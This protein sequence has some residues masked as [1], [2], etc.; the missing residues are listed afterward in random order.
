M[1]LFAA[2]QEIAGVYDR[3][4]N[5]TIILANQA[6]GNDSGSVNGALL[7]A[8]NTLSGGASTSIN[9]ALANLATVAGGSLEGIDT[10]AITALSGP[11]SN[12]VFALDP[13]TLADKSG[14]FPT[15]TATRASAKYSPIYDRTLTEFPVDQHTVWRGDWSGSAWS[16]NAAEA[17]ESHSGVTCSTVS[18]LYCSPA[19]TNILPYSDDLTGGSWT[20]GTATITA[21]AG[22]APDGTATASKVQNCPTTAGPSY[23][24]T[25]T[26]STYI[27]AG[28]WIKRISTTGTLIVQNVAGTGS[29]S[30][31][32]SLLDDGW[33]YIT[34]R[35]EGIVN[36]VNLQAD[37]SGNTGP[38]FVAAAGTVDF[39]VWG[40]TWLAGP[41]GISETVSIPTSGAE[42]TRA[43]DSAVAY[44]GGTVPNAG[45]VVMS[46]S[47]PYGV[48]Y[49][50]FSQRMLGAGGTGEN[51]D[52]RFASNG[53][54]VSCTTSTNGS[55]N[56][57]QAGTAGQYDMAREERVT[58]AFR[59][60]GS[61]AQLG[62]KKE[63]DAGTWLWG[64]ENVWNNAE[65]ADTLNL[66]NGPNSSSPDTVIHYAMVYNEC[67]T[68]AAIEAEFV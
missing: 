27:H 52:L 6:L 45:T 28:F 31:D 20:S 16:R 8:A 35:T 57:V 1:G 48:S 64:T 9:G 24:L 42:V 66:F 53:M 49:D 29:M 54:V 30:I 36:V 39:Y 61:V 5:E 62:I 63:Y 7:Q 15:V 60:G 58:I 67:L 26:A 33:N 68:T 12:V 51:F 17:T 19:R 25:T 22:T 37:A 13:Y 32:L 43:T 46:F 14:T 59:Y 18:G 44:T 23:A 2:L 34:H 65:M 3:S 50:Q 38:E 56:T 11:A 40:I 41:Y 55:I 47:F 10:A 21:N 4:Y